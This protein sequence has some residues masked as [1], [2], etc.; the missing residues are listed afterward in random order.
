MGPSN[1]REPGRLAL[2]TALGASLAAMLAACDVPARPDSWQPKPDPAPA[3]RERTSAVTLVS[4]ERER[5]RALDRP[6]DRLTVHLDRQPDHLNPMVVPSRWTRRIAHGP[7]FETLLRYGPPELGFG[8]VPYEP[9]LARSVDVS[10]DGRSIHIELR[11][12]ARFHDG[13]PLTAADVAFS[14]EVARTRPGASHLRGYFTDVTSVDVAGEHRLDIELS[15]RNSFVRRG[16]AE[17]PILPKHVYG[18]SLRSEPGRVVGTGPFALERWDETGVHLRRFS[19]YWGDEPAVREVVFDY[20]PDAARAL[21]LARR[22]AIDLLPEVGPAHI[23]ETKQTPQ[24]SGGLR[25]LAFRPPE[26]SLLALNSR[27]GALEDPDVRRALALAIDRGELASLARRGPAI[28][29]PGP[30]W[31]GGPVHGPPVPPFPHDPDTA[32]RLLDEVGWAMGSGSVR[33]RDGQPLRVTLLTPNG[34]DDPVREQIERDLRAVGAVVATEE[35]GSSVALA[36]RVRRGEFELA[37]V[38][39]RGEADR[40]PR[41]LLTGTFTPETEELAD[42]VATLRRARSARA[43]SEAA[44]SLAQAFAR[45][46]PWVPLTQPTPSGLVA[47]RVRGAR[48]WQGWIDLAAVELA[49]EDAVAGGESGEPGPTELIDLGFGLRFGLSFGRSLGH[50][51]GPPHGPALDSA[52]GATLDSPPDL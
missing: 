32:R 39:W 34:S 15:R 19:E 4:D 31:T 35:A 47:E 7:I 24:A 3:P 30:V 12:D 29:A 48:P 38:D 14:L 18:R 49:D 42:A 33:E 52:L 40:D 45:S 51:L 44:T 10:A 5:L 36:E 6:A 22:G 17:V 26:L 20:V 43:R 41:P 2:A 1:P 23:R 16:L 37:L 27:R 28:P 8:P 9:L 11:D 21:V 13:E 46:L 25:E 50:P